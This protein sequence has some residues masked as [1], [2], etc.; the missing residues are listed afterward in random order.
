M[1]HLRE[2][3]ILRMLFQ[4]LMKGVV[5]EEI[6]YMLAPPVR[7]HVYGYGPVENSLYVIMGADNSGCW[8]DTLGERAT[9]VRDD[10]KHV[11]DI[12][13]SHGYK[14]DMESMGVTRVET[15][16]SVQEPMRDTQENDDVVAEQRP[17]AGELPAVQPVLSN[18]RGHTGR[19]KKK[20]Q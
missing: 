16:E 8:S 12:L 14:L 9:A 2:N 5:M 20:G 10:L 15:Q 11:V 4:P 13:K 1:T 3:V 19:R 17:D 7:V 18:D 6:G